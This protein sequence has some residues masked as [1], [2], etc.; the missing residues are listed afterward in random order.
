HE[1]MV[2]RNGLGAAPP[3]P[4]GDGVLFVAFAA[5]A[6]LEVHLALGWPIP[7]NVLDLRV[8]HINQTGFSAKQEGQARE[9]SPRALL[10]VLRYYGIAD[11]DVAVKDAMRGVIMTRHWPTIEAKRSE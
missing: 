8:E 11:G 5:A 6:E 7:K 9:K 2:W 1:V 4:S 3:C 10:D